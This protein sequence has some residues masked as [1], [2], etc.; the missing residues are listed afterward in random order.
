[1]SPQ[2]IDENKPGPEC[3]NQN[4]QK[5]ITDGGSSESNSSRRKV[6]KILGI[7]TVGGGAYATGKS[8]LID[9]IS[10]S[11]TDSESNHDKQYS[12]LRSAA[13]DLKDIREETQKRTSWP[14]FSASD[15]VS[16]AVTYD[17]EP[18]EYDSLENSSISSFEAV[19]LSNRPAD[20]L[21]IEPGRQSTL[22]DIVNIL[23]LTHDLTKQSELNSS[24]DGETITMEGEVDEIGVFVGTYNEAVFAA[25]G[26]TEEAVRQA[27]SKL[28]EF[29]E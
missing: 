11:S 8:D 7:T 3:L 2:R 4:T 5:L 12:S 20:R 15:V 19:P 6:L 17:Y 28:G 27:A 9:D 10:T 22:E 1:M 26:N 23:L 14:E 16:A 25:R 21:R 29:V 13:E 18:V 24:I